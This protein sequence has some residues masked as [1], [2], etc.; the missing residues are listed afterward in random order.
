MNVKESSSMKLK[1]VLRF[2]DNREAS[3]RTRHVASSGAT[4]AVPVVH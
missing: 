2:G 4:F 1:E 3:S